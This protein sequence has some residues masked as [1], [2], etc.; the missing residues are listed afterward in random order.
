MKMRIHASHIAARW[1]GTSGQHAREG[2]PVTCLR[3]LYRMGLYVPLS[4]L[5]EHQSEQSFGRAQYGKR[6]PFYRDD[7]V[8]HCLGCGRV[9]VSVGADVPLRCPSP[10]QPC[11]A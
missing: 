2:E 7:R 1:C 5:R 8:H 4:K 6:D 11:T 9:L 3:C 10:I